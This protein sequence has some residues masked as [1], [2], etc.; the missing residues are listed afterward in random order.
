MAQLR[1]TGHVLRMGDNGLPKPTAIFC[2]KLEEGTRSRGGQRKRYK[3]TLKANLK[4]CDIAPPE[5]EELVLD[6]SVWRSHCK[7][8]VQ[9]FE[10]G[11]FRTLEIKWEQLKIGTYLNAASFPCDV[12][13]N[14]CASR[15]GLYARRRTHLPT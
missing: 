9:Q 1:W 15:I 10:A 7:T 11:P 2:S 4:R 6:R 8:S 5:L 12:C 3:A 13:G 14:S